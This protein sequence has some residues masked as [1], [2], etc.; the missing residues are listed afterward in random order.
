MVAAVL[1]AAFALVGIANVLCGVWAYAL[2]HRAMGIA[3]GLLGAFLVAASFGFPDTGRQA[4]H[5]GTV[6]T[7]A[8]VP[9]V[10]R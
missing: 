1:V 7:E 8:E 10:G 6:I 2:R 3:M 4:E 9:A 5:R